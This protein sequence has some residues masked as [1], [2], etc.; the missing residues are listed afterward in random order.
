MHPSQLRNPS[1]SGAPVRPLPLSISQKAWPRGIVAAS[2]A[3]RTEVST[4][5]KPPSA[6]NTNVEGSQAT[7]STSGRGLAARILAPA[8]A[9]CLMAMG[10]PLYSFLSTVELPPL[11]QSLTSIA[12]GL[13][14][15]AAGMKAVYGE[16]LHLEL[17]RWGQLGF[18]LKWCGLKILWCTRQIICS[19]LI[20]FM[21]C[22]SKVLKTLHLKLP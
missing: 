21:V 9:T 6:A 20:C 5:N 22:R 17:H 19:Y 4:L 8:A 2:Q 1:P 13:I 10:Q 15:L 12:A 16:K 7:A 18:K 14:A 11:S 3:D